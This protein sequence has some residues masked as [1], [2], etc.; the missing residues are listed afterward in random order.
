M[1]LTEKQAIDK[2]NSII[3]QSGLSGE[4]RVYQIQDA[5]WGWVMH[6]MP[7]D[8]S[9]ILYG[10]SSYLCHRNG[11]IKE[12]NDVAFRH[13]LRLE[14]PELVFKAFIQEAERVYNLYK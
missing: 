3:S 1:V 9:L 7:P 2:V 14:S 10:S 8:P 4:Y 11:Y 12:F 13:G 5:N 6:W